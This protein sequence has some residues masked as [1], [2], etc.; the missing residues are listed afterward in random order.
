MHRLAW[1]A[2]AVAAAGGCSKGLGPK[3]VELTI[4]TLAAAISDADVATVTAL[5]LTLS[6]NQNDHTRYDLTRALQRKETLVLH[7]T[8]STGDLTVGV[9]ARDAQG[10]VVAVG[11]TTSTLA[12]SDAH[13][14][15]VDMELPPDGPHAMSAVGLSL[16]HAQVFAGQTVPL[17]SPSPVS[18]AVA[19]GGAGG[20][21]DDKGLYSAPNASGSDVI[22]ATSS[23]YFGETRSTTIDVLT[24]GVLRWAGL[25][26]GAGTLDGVG[27]AAR[28][29]YVQGI[30]P[31]GQ[32]HVYFSDS[33][34]VIRKVD[35]ASGAV[36]TLAG[37]VENNVFADGPGK[38]AGFVRPWGVA[39]DAVRGALYVADGQTIR[40]VMVAD[41][42]TSTLV[43]QPFR[44]GNMDGTGSAASFQEIW[45]LAYDGQNH[46]YVADAP[47]SQIRV[48]DVESA[49]VTTLAGVANGV[50]YADGPGATARFNFP[51]GMAL[52]GAGHL[53]VSDNNQLI[54]AIDLA[55]GMVSTLAGKV[56]VAGFTDGPPGVGTLNFPNQ[57]SYL[58]GTLYLSGRVIDVATGTITTRAMDNWAPIDSLAFAPD[59]TLWAGGLSFIETVNLSTFDLT[60][61]AGVP[62]TY[63][64]L[65]DRQNGSRFVARFNDPLG[66]T[67]AADGTVY[68]RD[69]STVRKIDPDAGTVGGVYAGDYQGGGNLSV[70]GNGDIYYAA[71]NAIYRL[72]ASDGFAAPHLWAGSNDF[73]Y[74]EGS[75]TDARFA[76][77]TDVVIVGRT[78]YVA[79][80]GNN[81]V[82]AID[83]NAGMVSTLAGTA[84]MGGL[85]DMPGAMAR[86]NGPHGI[87]SDGAGALYVASNNALRK[88]V[89]AGAAVSTVAGGDLPG[90]ADGTGASAKLNTPTCVAWDQTRS[91]VFV[92]DLKNTAIRQVTPAGVVTT[93][94]G[95]PGRPYLSPGALPATINEP[96]AITVAPSGDLFVVVLH[97]ESLLQ[98]RLP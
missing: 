29:A 27:A 35:A 43:G 23:L 82:R 57:V 28:V 7:L 72:I 83:M 10:L 39:Y 90:F 59:G 9:L 1:V 16:D 92:G 21:V 88:I 22:T 49:A 26:A 19:P 97:E 33:S 94:A 80:T 13:L 38:S 40:K 75:L 96:T 78:M 69:G 73:G 56:G 81:I 58:N 76:G 60:P 70:D 24:S 74:A 61:V 30:A 91:V 12:G 71:N 86:F 44:F 32:G 64:D 65:N 14:V 55:S 25:P 4:D 62:I 79:D 54:R 89:I 63:N 18:W 15:A 3:D 8:T 46:L 51:T 50:G 42:A 36:T 41:G 17:A 31:D 11:N 45:E 68:V 87:A 84:H 37:T 66:V 52:D 5:E 2:L 6:G 93:V 48:V 67:T 53:F 34:N 47:G 95:A 98:I 85:V 77:L 20:T